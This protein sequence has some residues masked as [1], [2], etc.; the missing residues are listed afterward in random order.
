MG[1][2]EWALQIAGAALTTGGSL[3][4]KKTLNRNELGLEPVLVVISSC[5]HSEGEGRHPAEMFAGLK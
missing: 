2:C 1:S 4:K 3:K 5:L